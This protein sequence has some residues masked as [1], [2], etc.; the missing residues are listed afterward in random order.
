M[1]LP[2]SSRVEMRD[3]RPTLLLNDSPVAPLIYALSDCPGARWSWEEVP[4]RNISEFGK[5]GVRLFQ[6]DVWLNQMLDDSGELD[7]T[8]ARR[9]IAGV[10]AAAPE[11]AVMLRLHLNPSKEW[12]QQNPE[13]W[14]GYADTEP[15]D[16][17]IHGLH[18][19]LAHDGASPISGE[20]LF[21]QVAGLGPH[22]VT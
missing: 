18:R 8:L 19:P 1:P 13:E 4:T 7:V 20:F 16:P 2:L 17:P 22:Q 21:R 3:D 5:R 15:V 9:Q 14:V 6:V 11:A 10:T 12:I